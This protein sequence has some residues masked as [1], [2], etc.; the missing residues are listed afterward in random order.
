MLLVATICISN[1]F[2][3]VVEWTAV[4]SCKL[5]VQYEDPR[6]VIMMSESHRPEH[7][8]SLA[9]IAHRAHISDM[10]MLQVDPKGHQVGRQSIGSLCSEPSRRCRLPSLN[11]LGVVQ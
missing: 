6:G 5:T 1:T 9:S 7:H 2:S 8:N 3:G 11:V 4:A 10:K